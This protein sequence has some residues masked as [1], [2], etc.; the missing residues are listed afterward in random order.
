M[1]VETSAIMLY[2]QIT[3]IPLLL[4][5]DRL[6]LIKTTTQ[7]LQNHRDRRIHLHEL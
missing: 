7:R 6:L 1:Q 3:N 2:M 5:V 4:N